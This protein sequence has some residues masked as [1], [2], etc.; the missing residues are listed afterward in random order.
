MFSK[1]IMPDSFYSEAVISSLSS[2]YLG[3]SIFFEIL[4][5]ENAFLNYLNT[6]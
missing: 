4:C 3:R 6:C 1:D 2:K 5:F